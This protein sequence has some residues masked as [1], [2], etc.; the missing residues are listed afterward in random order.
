[1]VG[2]NGLDVTSLR[3]FDLV[4][5]FTIKKG[6]ITGEWEQEGGWEPQ[7]WLEGTRMCQQAALTLSRCPAGEVRM[8]SGKVAQPAITDNKDGTVTVRYAPSEAGLH[9]MD[10]RYD[11]MHIP[12]A[13]PQH[14]TT[15]SQW[16]GAAGG[17]GG[18]RKVPIPHGPSS[19][20][21]KPPAVLRGLRQLWPRHR[22]RARPHPRSSEQAC[23][24][25]SQH[26]GRRRG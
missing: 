7:R 12:G 4:I 23:C 5:P 11:N 20:L 17:L 21:R 14:A 26:Q 15:A 16:P 24:L 25:H 18:Q 6:E 19:C 13:L 2:V 1:M 3:P 8:P 22:L 10:I 9:E